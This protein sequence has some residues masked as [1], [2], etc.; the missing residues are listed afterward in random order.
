MSSRICP[1]CG[2]CFSRSKKVLGIRHCP[3][4]SIALYYP[5]GKRSGQTLLWSDKECADKLVRTLEKHI[6]KKNDLIYEDDDGNVI[7]GFGFGFS[8][9]SVELVHAYALVERSRD[10]LNA[11]PDNLGLTPDCFIAEVFEVLLK[12]AYYSDITSLV[13]VRNSISD[14]ALKLF[15]HKKLDK[16]KERLEQ[17]RLEKSLSGKEHMVL[18]YGIV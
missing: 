2:N 7:Y 6:S 13:R 10:F 11:V 1:Q 15:K 9:K 3:A 8:E 18:S 4:C 14:V 12:D 16:Q 5:S 17:S